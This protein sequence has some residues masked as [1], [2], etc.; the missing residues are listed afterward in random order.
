M[1]VLDITNRHSREQAQAD[2]NVALLIVHPEE[3]LDVQSMLT[4][5]EGA[6]IIHSEPGLD[7][8]TL[9]YV[10]CADE[11]EREGLERAWMSFERFRRVLPPLR[12]KRSD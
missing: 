5:R 10:R 3:R 1:N 2:A 4:G 7:E 8:D 12:I 11:G 6:R 9:L